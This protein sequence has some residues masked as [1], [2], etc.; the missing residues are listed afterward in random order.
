MHAHLIPFP[1]GSEAAAPPAGSI[2]TCRLDAADGSGWLL[3]LTDGEGA[4]FEVEYI[5]AHAHGAGSTAA[6][7]E[8]S[9]PRDAAQIAADRRASRDRVGPAAMQVQG[10]L[11]ALVLRAEDGAGMTIYAAE[12]G[13]PTAQA[14]ALLASWAATS[15]SAPAASQR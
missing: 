1:P 13:S 15:E 3:A 2:A 7:V 4:A 14:L 11:G 8:F 12:P 5:D 9:G 6:V 10:N